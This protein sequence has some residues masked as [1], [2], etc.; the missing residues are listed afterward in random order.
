MTY[1]AAAKYMGR[2]KSCVSNFMPFKE[3]TVA[4]QI[5]QRVFSQIIE[6]QPNRETSYYSSRSSHHNRVLYS[7]KQTIAYRLK[8]LDVEIPSARNNLLTKGSDM[9]EEKNNTKLYDYITETSSVFMVLKEHI[10]V[11]RIHLEMSD[12]G[13]SLG[14]KSGEYGG[15]H[16]IKT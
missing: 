16:T 4:G 10:D 15:L 5:T 9:M 2:S 12:N 8:P 1:A 11:A 3:Y 14:V 13:K 6:S 7:V